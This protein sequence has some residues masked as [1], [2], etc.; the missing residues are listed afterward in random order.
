MLYLS[1]Q[2]TSAVKCF[3]KR[4]NFAFSCYFWY[5]FF[6]HA[7]DHRVIF[8]SINDLL[9]SRLCTCFRA[10]K[11]TLTNE[12][13]ESS[14]YKL[15]G[16][17]HSSGCIW[18]CFLLRLDVFCCWYGFFSIWAHKLELEALLWQSKASI[19]RFVIW[20][21]CV[22]VHLIVIMRVERNQPDSVSGL[23]QLRN[24]SISFPNT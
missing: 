16:D 12:L 24:S 18:C 3:Q 5:A 15:F 7:H 6:I 21:V 9:H 11:K 20:W 13:I 1:A 8:F 10:R 14:K 4:K 2:L 23:F 19:V 17:F 22:C